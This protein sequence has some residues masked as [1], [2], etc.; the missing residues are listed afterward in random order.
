[1][2]EASGTSMNPQAGSLPRIGAK[3]LV[4]LDVHGEA[5]MVRYAA[6]R[7]VGGRQVFFPNKGFIDR[8]RA[9]MARGA[10]CFNSWG[11]L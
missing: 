8:R 1:M 11:A 7:P 4:E 6:I 5:Y 10:S 9:S 2:D 3:R